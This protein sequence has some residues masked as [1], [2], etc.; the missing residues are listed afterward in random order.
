MYNTNIATLLC[1]ILI[2]V[3]FVCNAFYSQQDFPRLVFKKE[4]LE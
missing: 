1:A 2:I 3:T 4:H